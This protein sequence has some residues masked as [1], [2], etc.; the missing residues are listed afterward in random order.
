M[1]MTLPDSLI[2]LAFLC[3][4]L[5]GDPPWM[6]HPVRITGRVALGLESLLRKSRLPLRFAGIL[7]VVLLVWGAVVGT[8]WLV[9]LSF[10]FHPV[11]GFVVVLYLLYSSFAVK[12]LADHADA[13]R[14][15]LEQGDLDEARRRVSM[16]VGR[17]TAELTESEVALAASESVAE[18]SV[19]GVLAPLFYAVLFGPVGA[20]VFKVISTLDST[21][22]YKNERYREFGWAAARLDDVANFVPARLGVLVI[23]LAAFVARFRVVDLF[24][25][26][27]V[28]A[29][30]HASPNAGFPEAAYAGALGVSFGGRRSY[31]GVVSEAPLLGFGTEPCSATTIAE[32][33]RLMRLSASLFV[34]LGIGFRVLLHLAG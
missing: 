31:G 6:P 15:A 3:D 11:A 12:D 20:V 34:G 9:S 7:A 23:A 33:V 22:G 19:D 4:L 24:R 13:V 5:F 30:R 26:V 2:V 28:G 14:K 27:A 1:R 10:L 29:R 18:N 32:S 8:Q 21:F 17:D 25:A 16:I